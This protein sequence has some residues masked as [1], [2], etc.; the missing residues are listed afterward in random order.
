MS[1]KQDHGEPDSPT[2]AKNNTVDAV[3]AAILFAFGLVVIV[4]ARRLGAG[5]TSDGPGAG[6]FPFYIGLIICISALGIIYQAKFSAQRDTGT[7]VDREQ[8]KR[9]LAV[10]LPAGVYVLAT[11]LLG[12]YIASA[13]YITLFMIIMGKYSAFKS[14]TV[15]VVVNTVFFMM[16]EVWFK[17]PLYKGTL[18][19]LRFLGY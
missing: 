16:F 18:D 7:F 13:I 3:V 17:V 1:D 12:L 8:F 4:E 6:Y 9:V 19:P 10:L 14:V 5:W 15:A 2:L 11:V